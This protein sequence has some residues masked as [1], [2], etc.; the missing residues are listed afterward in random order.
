M[1]HSDRATEAP[2]AVIL[3]FYGF[4]FVTCSGFAVISFAVSLLLGLR[5]IVQGSSR[6]LGPP[7]RG[8]LIISSCIPI[9]PYVYKHVTL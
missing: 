8:P 5:S 9:Y 4:Y 2:L 7:V 6:Y 3:Q 1:L